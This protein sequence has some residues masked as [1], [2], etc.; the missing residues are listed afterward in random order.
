MRT[1][2]IDILLT[3]CVF[4]HFIMQNKY[5]T[6]TIVLHSRERTLV[7]MVNQWKD[8]TSTIIFAEEEMMVHHDAFAAK[9]TS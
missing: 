8:I 3:L 6:V 1:Q 7:K 5:I 4:I 2:H 9:M